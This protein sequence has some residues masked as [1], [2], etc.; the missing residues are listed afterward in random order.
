MLR[1]EA[2]D[3]VTFLAEP[4]LP[5]PDASVVIFSAAPRLTAPSLRVSG[6]EARKPLGA[7]PANAVLR[8]AG[9]GVVHLQAAGS[10]T[11]GA[12]LQA[13]VFSGFRESARA[14]RAALAPRVTRWPS[15]GCATA[16]AL[17]CVAALLLR[18]PFTAACP[19]RAADALRVITPGVVSLL[20]SATLAAS[21]RGVAALTG[22][23]EL[24][25]PR[26]PIALRVTGAGN[27][28]L[29]ALDVGEVCFAFWR[30]SKGAGPDP[31]ERRPERFVAL[32]GDERAGADTF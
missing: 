26:V 28:R 6:P 21:D 9:V 25:E 19:A 10:L 3:V 11:T 1:G 15:E 23:R 14:A 17:L 30:S 31:H 18:V 32:L 2:G 22:A 4:D 20:A 24:R 29:R 7:A 13:S 12:S 16:S 8:V 27:V 5:A